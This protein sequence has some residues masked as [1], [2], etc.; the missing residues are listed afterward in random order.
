MYDMPSA[1]DIL[2]AVCVQ[3]LHHELPPCSHS[4]S[5]PLLNSSAAGPKHTPKLT[6][7]KDTRAGKSKTN[8]PEFSLIPHLSTF[9][10]VHHA[11]A[12]LLLLTDTSY[13]AANPP[14]ATAAVE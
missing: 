5:V 10:V 12:P 6:G 2:P 8:M 14:R 1:S 13:P 3:Q 9:V 4:H 7:V 11:V